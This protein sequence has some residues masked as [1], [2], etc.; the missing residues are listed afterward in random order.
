MRDDNDHNDQR[1][2]PRHSHWRPCPKC[3]G[4]RIPKVRFTMWGS[5]LG[6]ALLAHVRCQDCGCKFNGRSGR[7]NL[8]PIILFVSVPLSVIAGL[9]YWAYTILVERGYL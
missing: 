3:G 4:D 1:G 6:P 7:S 2:R 8:I 5:F 9:V